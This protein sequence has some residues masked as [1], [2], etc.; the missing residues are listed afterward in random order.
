MRRFAGAILALCL[1]ACGSLPTEDGVA[2]LDIIPP[3]S[4][5]IDVGGT[6]RI[7]ARALDANG[8]E[9]DVVIT[10]RT[11]D[12]TVSVDETGL[13]TGLAAGKGRVQASIGESRRLVSNFIEITVREP[14]PEETPHP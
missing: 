14:E 10:W 7:G 9:L 12:T 13:V 8:E 6:V 1:A 5:T 2:F 3:A 4:L 11:A